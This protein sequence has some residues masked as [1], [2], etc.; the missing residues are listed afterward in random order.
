MDLIESWKVLFSVSV[1]HAQ[2]LTILCVDT[3]EVKE[4]HSLS[5]SR[6]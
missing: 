6:A 4:E 1:H 2:V 5:Y 3:V